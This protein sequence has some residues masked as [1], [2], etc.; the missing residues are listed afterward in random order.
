MS[1]G[2][3][4]RPLPSPFIQGDYG[5]GIVRW[6]LRDAQPAGMREGP[7]SEQRGHSAQ[8]EK[9]RAMRSLYLNYAWVRVMR[10]R[11]TVP[12]VGS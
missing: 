9:R 10:P 7:L 4:A 6:M 12:F 8:Q 2:S 3:P 1:R 11:E 5:N